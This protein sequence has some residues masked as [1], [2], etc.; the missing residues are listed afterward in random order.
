MATVLYSNAG[1]LTIDES[2]AGSNLAGLTLT[3][4]ASATGTLYFK[5]TLTNPASNQSN[6][7]YYAGMQLWEGGSERMGI[8]NNWGAYAYSVFNTAVGEMDLKSATPEAGRTY[9]LVRAT[10][11]TTIVFKVSYSAVGN[12]TVTAW[13]NPNLSLTEAEQNPALVT[14]FQANATFTEIHLREGGVGAGWTFSNIAIADIAWDT[15]FFAVPSDSDNDGLPDL[16]EQQIITHAAGQEPPLALTLADIKG[17]NEAPTTSDYDT[18]GATDAAEYARECNPTNPDTD[19]DWLLDGVETKTGVWVSPTDRGTDPTRMDSDGDGFSDDFETNTGV[20]AGVNDPGTDPNKADTDGD[21]HSDSFE[22]TMGSDPTL[23]ASTPAQGDLALIGTDDFTYEDGDISNKTGGTSFDFDNSPFN[24]SFIGHTGTVSDWDVVSGTATV[25]GG[26]LVTQDSG[27]K[28]EFNGP[29]EDVVVNGDEY[30]GAVRADSDAKAVYLRADITRAA[31]ADW[32]G[33]SIYD[34]GAE[35][36]FFGV[37]NENG[38]SGSREFGIVHSGVGVTFGSGVPAIPAA[39]QTYTIVGK[40]DYANQL[41]SLWVNPDLTKT[42]AENTPYTT[43]VLTA[44]NWSTGFRLASGGTGAVTW[45]NAVAARQW[46]ALGVFPGTP[47]NT[48]Q[49]WI[50]G[51]PG[52]SGAS[53]F[54]DDADGDGIANGAEH[55]LGTDPSAPSQGLHEVSQAGGVFKFRHTRT[56]QQ[57]TDVQAT[58][59]WSTDLTNWYAPGATNPG[60]VTVAISTTTVTDTSAPDVDEIEVS[61]TVTAG[62]APRLFVRLVANQ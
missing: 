57:A 35:R 51:Y 34:F 56:N 27:A 6:E 5:Y 29:G 10:D 21:T 53:G 9:Q 58:Y 25:A 3:R 13:L 33:M 15:G 32:S 50:A 54:A 42:E 36:V 61:A 19:N 22:T 11:V 59:A 2:G 39:G 30:I 60:G 31:G 7:N 46:S 28:R 40:L 16:W 37:P 55:L 41:L 20:F 48:Y 24:N 14:T 23:A 62:T 45:D 52:A 17:P 26:K 4:D 44:T 18:D 1:P 49:T 8:G 12:D 47:A 38:P 43:R